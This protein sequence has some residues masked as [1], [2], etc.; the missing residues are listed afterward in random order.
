MQPNITLRP[1]NINDMSRIF[2]WRNDV[3]VRKWSLSSSK[4]NWKTHQEW[5][6]NTLKNPH[7]SLLIAMD[8]WQPL[9]VVRL[10]KEFD[11]AE[12]S[13]FLSPTFIGK[14]FGEAMIRAGQQWASMHLVDVKKI[15]AKVLME[16]IASQKVF[17]RAGFV[18]HHR[19]SEQDQEKGIVYYYELQGE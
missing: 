5:F 4:I 11:T 12:I 1:A 3:E 9:G 13:V 14:G 7:R 19:W 18:E 2:Y 15:K 10:D 17:A 8:V 6:E 16:N